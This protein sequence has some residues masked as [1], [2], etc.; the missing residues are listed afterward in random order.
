MHIKR[1]KQTHALYSRRQGQRTPPPCCSLPPP[2]FPPLLSPLPPL[3]LLFS[4]LSLPSLFFSSLLYPLF[5]SPP[6]ILPSH[7][8]YLFICPLLS[9]LLPLPFS[10][11]FSSLSLLSFFP[12]FCFPSSTFPHYSRYLFTCPLFSPLYIK[13]L[14]VLFDFLPD[15]FYF[16]LSRFSVISLFN[17]FVAL[18]CVT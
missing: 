8:Y 1:R 9:P 10:L 13:I 5:C 2:L 3:S 6:S 11:F 18:S 14:F 15:I 4:K 7:S 16:V 17:V 12:L